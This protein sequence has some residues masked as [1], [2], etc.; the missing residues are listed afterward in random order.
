VTNQPT[1]QEPSRSV[2]NFQ[3]GHDNGDLGSDHLSLVLPIYRV[4]TLTIIASMIWKY[5]YFIPIFQSYA[6]LE[7][8]DSFFPPFLTSL[9]VL[10]GLYLAPIAFGI[11]ALFT[12]SITLLRAQALT[13]LSCMFGLCI[14][15]GSYN[16]VTFVTCLWVSLWCVWYTLK[17]NEPPEEL[18]KKSQRFSLLIISLIFLGGAAGKWTPGYWS[19]EVIYEIYFSHRDFWF[20]NLLRNQLDSESLRNVATLYSRVIVLSE[21][22][23][24]FLWLLKPKHGG[25][26]AIAMLLGITFLSNLLLFSVTFCLL[27]LAIVAIE[28][29][30]WKATATNR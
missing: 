25:M 11:I 19:G 21:T 14:H 15:Q 5:A 1:T 23:C 18:L 27:G 2:R 24:A 30:R 16:D 17:I 6:Q 4:V 13:T 28:T 7:I 29:P 10:A 8:T 12:R 26:I 9:Y 3:N 20:F 22:A